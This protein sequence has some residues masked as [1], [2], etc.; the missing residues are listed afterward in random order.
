LGVEYT[1]K[2]SFREAEKN[3]AE[4]KSAVRIIRSCVFKFAVFAL[5]FI[6]NDSVAS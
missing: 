2:G 5:K 6:P 1:L 3:R 4:E